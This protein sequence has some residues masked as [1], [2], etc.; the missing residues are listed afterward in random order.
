[1]V[2]YTLDAL[3]TFEINGITAS[4]AYTFTV[5]DFIH[6]D[7]TIAVAGLTACSVMTNTGPG[8]CLAPSFLYGIDEPASDDEVAT[9]K[10]TPPGGGP[11]DWVE[12]YYYFAPGSFEHVGSY[13][14][15]FFGT[16]QQAI[17]TVTA[18][19]VDEP[20]S[21][22]LLAAGLGVAGVL[23]RRSRRR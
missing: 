22:A 9:L 5:P 12:Y 10:L 4:G 11:N 23:A 2:T 19:A 17:L 7:T 8:T 16:D 18:T 20:S 6:A 15:D 13:G 3:S 14:S 21:L 1:S